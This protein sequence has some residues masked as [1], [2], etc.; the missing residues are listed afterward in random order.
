MKEAVEFL[1]GAG[2]SLLAVIEQSAK[3]AECEINPIVQSQHI[4]VVSAAGRAI[5]DVISWKNACE[6]E[7]AAAVDLALVNERMK[8]GATVGDPPD[9]TV[10][11][12]GVRI[13]LSA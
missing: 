7:I 4:A 2:R 11:R 1:N 9:G 8:N 10:S 12:N 13:D 6:E 3:N 5:V